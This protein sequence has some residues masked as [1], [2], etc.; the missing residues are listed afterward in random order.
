MWEAIEYPLYKFQCYGKTV[1]VVC[2]KIYFVVVCDERHALQE[3]KFFTE[4]CSVCKLPMCVPIQDI[5]TRTT[6]KI[7]ESCDSLDVAGA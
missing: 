3:V 2:G 5:Q 7:Q 1:F 6:W 4:N